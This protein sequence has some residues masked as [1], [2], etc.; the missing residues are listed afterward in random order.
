MAAIGGDLGGPCGPGSTAEATLTPRPAMTDTTTVLGGEHDARRRGCRCPRPASSA[1]SSRRHAD[2]G[3]EAD[4]RGD[5]PDDDGLEQHRPEHLTAAGT[6]GPH[7]RHLL[8]A[9]GDE[10]RE[11]VVDD[12]RADE[13][14]DDGEDQQEGVEEAHA[15]LDRPAGPRR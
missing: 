9:L 1:F 13:Q 10:D 3:G 15:L 6:D 8:A 4:G 14:G 7:Q 11:G 5:E 2:A 12:E